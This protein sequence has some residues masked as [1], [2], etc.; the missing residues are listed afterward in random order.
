MSSEV[1]EFLT[2]NPVTYL[3]SV[4]KDGN[5]HVRPIMFVLEQFGNPYFA[6]TN[7]KPMYVQV[8]AHPRVEVAAFDPKKN[9]WLRI[10]ANVV[11]TDDEGI[12][13]DVYQAHPFMKKF[14]KSFED[15]KF[16]VFTL[17]G[18]AVIAGCEKKPPKS[19]TLKG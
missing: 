1:I 11:F 15:P 9:A 6:T 19:Y 4:D 13:N 12:K 5:P 17:A 2:K 14:F 10:L 18:T 3:A 7:T 16:E 8:K